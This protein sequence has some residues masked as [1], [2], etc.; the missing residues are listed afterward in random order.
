[1][2]STP[3]PIY[4]LPSPAQMALAAWATAS[5]PEPQRRFTVQ[6]ATSTGKPARRRAMR[7]TL[8]LSSPAWLAQPA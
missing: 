5:S 3:L 8:R 2:D 4:T 1:M 6:P 7:A